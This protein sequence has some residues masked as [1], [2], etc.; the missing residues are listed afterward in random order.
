MKHE[1]EKRTESVAETPKT[2]G[3]FE[4]WKHVGATRA[5]RVGVK[6]TA[7]TDSMLAVYKDNL[8]YTFILDREVSSIHFDRM[9]GEIF[10]RGHNI[11]NIELTQRQIQAL[12]D[13]KAILSQDERGTPF[14]S[15]YVATLDRY[16]ADKK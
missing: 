15:D 2:H 9:R 4:L 3:I 12:E 1:R 6:G 7:G 11:K 16:L 5:R 8:T 10:F 13:L 14:L